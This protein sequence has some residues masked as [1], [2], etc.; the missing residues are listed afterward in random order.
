[1]GVDAGSVAQL[2]LCLQEPELTLKRIAASA[3]SEIAKHSPELAHAVVDAGAVAYLAPLIQHPDAKL[4]RQVCSALAQIAKHSVEL[5][6][7]VVE[8]EI[9]PKILT[10][11]KDLDLVVRKNSATLIREIAKHTPE[12]ATLIVNAGGH[13]AMID[14]ITESKGAGRLPGIMTLGYIAAFSETLAL[15]IIVHQGILPLKDSLVSESEDHIKAAA[16]WSLCQIGRHT[17]DHA[18]A[19]AVADV[20]GKLIEVYASNESSEDLKKKAQSGLKNVLQKCTYLPA[21]EPLLQT[22]PDAKIKKYLIQQ[23]AKIL[24]T[25]PAARKSFVQSGCLKIVQELK[26]EEGSKLQEYI[27]TINSCYA[28]EIVQ[29]F[30]PNYAQTLLKKLDDY[31]DAK[32]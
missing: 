27:N 32:S 7:V 18:R 30:S 12:L 31:E 4:K 11:L 13:A 16:A 23:F 26:A 21:L 29:Y 20:F 22:A 24:P 5:A 8:A 2:V 9:F 10:C 1:M 3:L 15:A 28:P 17:P 25:N 19:L 14:Y 6:E